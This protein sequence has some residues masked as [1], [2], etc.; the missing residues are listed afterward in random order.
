MRAEIRWKE[1]VRMLEYPPSRP[2]LCPQKQG[3][4]EKDAP[5]FYSSGIPNCGEP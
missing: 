5:D 2:G 4:L 1:S 3:G